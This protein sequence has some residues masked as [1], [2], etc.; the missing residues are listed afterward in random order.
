MVYNMDNQYQLTNILKE[1]RK[2][3]STLT[4]DD[5]GKLVGCTRQTIIALEQ[6]KYNPSL[7]LALNLAK[8]LKSSV[9]E[10]F[11]LK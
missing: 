10:I 6:N 11:F 7:Y 9:D 2:E 5:L 3:L 8:V 4:Q 1:K